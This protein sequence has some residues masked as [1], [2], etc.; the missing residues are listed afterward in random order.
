MQK[1]SKKQMISVAFLLVLFLGVVGIVHEGFVIAREMRDSKQENLRLLQ[2]RFEELNAE[3]VPDDGNTFTL[4]GMEIILGQTTVQ[5][6]LDQTEFRVVADRAY[7]YISDYTYSTYIKKKTDEI[8]KLKSISPFGSGTVPVYLTGYSYNVVLSVES[9]VLT[10]GEDS[11]SREL[12]DYEDCYINQISITYEPGE[13][14]YDF[15]YAGIDP[16]MSHEEIVET[17]GEPDMFG[18]TSGDVSFVYYEW[19]IGRTGY[20]EETFNYN[21]SDKKELNSVTYEIRD[22]YY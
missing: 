14:G 8:R 20:L 17:L 13:K 4:E 9:C 15:S 19:S 2:E 10:D 18:P 22:R 1:M 3:I 21:D 12:P 7:Y 5:D 16:T 6:V 11:W